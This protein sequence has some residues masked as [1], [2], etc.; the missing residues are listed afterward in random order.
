MEELLAADEI[1]FGESGIGRPKLKRFLADVKDGITY[2]S[3]W[4]FVPLNTAGSS[5]MQRIFGDPTAFE[6]PKPSGLI[7]ELAHLGSES[8]DI[9]LDFFAGSGSTAH[10]VM[11]QNA[12]DDVGTSSCSCPSR[13]IHPG[14]STT[15]R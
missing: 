3:I 5:E 13:S 15:A 8:D 1:T 9:I 7:T 6:S 10:A 12:E 4:D 11:Q 2:P 14:R